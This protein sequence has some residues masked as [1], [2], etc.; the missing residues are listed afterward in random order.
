MLVY[1]SFMHKK[2]STRIMTH[3]NDSIHTVLFG[4]TVRDIP[5]KSVWARYGTVP[6]FTVRRRA[7]R[8]NTVKLTFGI[9]SKSVGSK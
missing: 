3:Q 2:E 6:Y 8:Y 9:V 7:V 4:R 5:F 1:A